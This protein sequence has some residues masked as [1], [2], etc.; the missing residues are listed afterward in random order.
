MSIKDIETLLKPLAEQYFGATE[1]VYGFEEI[2]TKI[3]ELEKSKIDTLKADVEESYHQA[4]G[5]F[6]EAGEDQQKYLQMFAFICS[7]SFDVYVKKL[8]IEKLVDEITSEENGK[9]KK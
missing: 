1:E 3:C 9:K 7:L 5:M 8:L 2:Y 6:E 4:E